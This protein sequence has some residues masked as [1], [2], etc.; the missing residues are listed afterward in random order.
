MHQVSLHSGTVFLSV[1]VVVV[2]LGLL[3]EK[4]LY[5]LICSR[6]CWKVDL[7]TVLAVDPYANLKT[8][9]YPTDAL[10]SSFL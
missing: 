1:A 8:L 6:S 9:F 4:A 7:V 10:S 3:L 5:L 2:A